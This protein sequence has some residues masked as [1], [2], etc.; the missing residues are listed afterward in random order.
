MKLLVFAHIPPPHHGQSYMVKLMLE[1]F[2]GDRRSKGSSASSEDGR[3][4]ECYHVNAQYS[5]DLES[6]GSFQW[7]K[8]LLVLRYC[9][10]AIWCRFRY[11]IHVFYYVPAPGKR[12]ALYRDWIVMLLCRPF[13]R[14]MVYHWHA[15]GL[16]DWLERE[17]SVL[18][19]WI[20]QR[21]L[22]RPDLSIALATAST[23]DALWLRSDRVEIVANGIPDPEPEFKESVLPQRQARLAV[24]RKLLAGEESTDEERATAGPPPEVF[25]VLYLAHC[26]ATKG[27]FDALDGV[28]LASQR[29]A[30]RSSR[31]RLHLSVAGGF[32][33]GAEQTAFEARLEHADLKGLVTYL[34]FVSGEAKKQLLRSH[35]ALCFPTFYDAES[36]GLV[37]VEGMAAGQTIITTRWRAIPELLP[38]D[39]PSLVA[40]RS[41]D[42]VADA[43][44]AAVD[45]IDA[46]L[47]RDHFLRHFALERHLEALAQALRTIG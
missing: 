3:G 33:D 19:R 41:P 22:G 44:L 26:T 6:V 34:G 5:D 39:Y 47:L 2:G 11:G 46:E 14:R 17:R 40:P 12:A 4:I 28:A 23:Q 16:T 15:V 24:R 38:V 27:L 36:F 29:L 18:E 30:E 9:S 31:L 25:R 42:Q 32:L 13:F 20:T 7:K 35:D 10:E 21:L 37:V 8:V 45:R 43:L 1:G